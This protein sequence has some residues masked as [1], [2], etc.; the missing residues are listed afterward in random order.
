[1]G[2]AVTA[3]RANPDDAEELTRLRVVMFD[4]MGHDVTS[5]DAPWRQ[6]TAE[7]FRARLHDTGEFAAF[8]V[9]RASRPSTCTRLATASRSTARSGSPNRTPRR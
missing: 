8:V 6:R 3:R 2:M 4:G 9:R 7:H 5:A 1:M